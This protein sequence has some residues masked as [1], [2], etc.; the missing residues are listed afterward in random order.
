LSTNKEREKINT[1]WAAFNGCDFELSA[2]TNGL[3]D[4][5]L[6]IVLTYAKEGADT[7]ELMK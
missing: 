3:S 6:Y 1:E 2:T 5:I 7:S 4:T